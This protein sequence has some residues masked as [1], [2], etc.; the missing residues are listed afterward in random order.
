MVGEAV[1]VPLQGCDLA[2]CTS[3]TAIVTDP[4]HVVA[5]DCQHLPAPP[6]LS[7]G[8]LGRARLAGRPAQVAAT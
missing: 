5:C 6:W 2:T 8:G 1:V 4:Y 7:L 3:A